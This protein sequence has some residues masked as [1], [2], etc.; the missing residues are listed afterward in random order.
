[1]VVSLLTSYLPTIANS[2]VIRTIY[3]LS[4]NNNNSLHVRII[5]YIIFSTLINI[6]N[7]IFKRFLF[8]FGFAFISSI[9]SVITAV[10][11]IFWIPQLRNIQSLLNFAFN[12]KNIID[13][14]LPFNWEIPIPDIFKNK[15]LLV[16]SLGFLGLPILTF[17]YPVWLSNILNYVDFYSYFGIFSKPIKG[18]ATFLIY[19][20]A[21]KFT[22]VNNYT[23]L[24]H[25]EWKNKI[26]N[27][28]PFYSYPF[29][30]S[31]KGYGRGHKGQDNEI[32]KEIHEVNI[33]T[34][35]FIFNK[36]D[37]NKFLD[38]LFNE[39]NIF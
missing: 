18:L 22:D 2:S 31:L 34:N 26:Q 12:M 30:F 16:L 27:Y 23:S 9:F 36:I 3:R 1:M 20:L 17:F 4:R 6:F 33:K 5:N 32:S 13:I 7:F 21:S 24:P 11:G 14:Y 39:L 29:P 19:Y 38:Y 10:L 15:R 8:Y 37:L 28:S 35:D 25:L